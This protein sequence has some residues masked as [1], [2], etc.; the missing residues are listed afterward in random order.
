M[1]QDTLFTVPVDE[2][3]LS[4]AERTILESIDQ[5]G[6]ISAHEAGT[7]V[8][9]LRGYHSILFV[10]RAWVTSSGAR[11]LEKLEAAGLLRRTRHRRWK[12]RPDL[13]GRP[14]GTDVI[15]TLKTPKVSRLFAGAL[16]QASPGH[17]HDTPALC[18]FWGLRRPVTSSDSGLVASRGCS[19]YAPGRTE[20]PAAAPSDRAEVRA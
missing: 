2:R 1:T 10:R 13:I 16:S 14:L 4:D 20:P 7:I 19:R 9:R 15:S 12:R 17:A 5:A 3:C 11:V 8:Y 6:P 18:D